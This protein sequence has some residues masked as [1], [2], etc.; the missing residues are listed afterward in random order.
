MAHRV[1]IFEQ[2]PPSVMHYEEVEVSAPGPSQIRIKQE[3]SGVNFVDTM[4]RDGTIKMPLP[5]DMGV[6][7]AGIVEAIGEAT[8]GFNV[9]D[10]VAYW[11]APGAYTDQRLVQAD[12]LVRLPQSVSAITAAALMAKGLTAWSAVK[13]IHQVVPGET[14]LVNGA[15]GGVGLLVATWAKALGA[16]VIA[17]VG[18]PSKAAALTQRGIPHVLDAND[19]KWVSK[20]AHLTQG[21]GVD[22][23]F[24]LVGGP[25][26]AKSVET[27]RDGAAIVHIGNASGSIAVDKE[28]LASRSIT[29]TKYSTAQV[30]HNRHI[31][32]LA[33]SDLFQALESNV[34]GEIEISTFS[35]A[36]ANRAHEALAARTVTG[37][38]V[39]TS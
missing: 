28:L 34:F 24:E 3:A 29:F 18:S 22:V 30:I 9:G 32:E 25:N 5:F 15:A 26:F 14:V 37:S 31:L 17:L 6:E 16:L 4:F 12:L 38:I 35:L 23:S 33:S 27:L 8:R 11:F 20:V 39:L 1:R 21:R 10:R 7:G 13:Q 19:P 36:E 2:G